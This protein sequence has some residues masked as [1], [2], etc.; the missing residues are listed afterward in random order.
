MTFFWRATTVAL[1]SYVVIHSEDVASCKWCNTL[2]GLEGKKQ[3]KTALFAFEATLCKV[4]HAS[5]H[6]LSPLPPAGGAYPSCRA[7]A[8]W[9][10]IQP[11]TLTHTHLRAIWSFSIV[12]TCMFLDYARNM[13]SPHRKVRGPGIEPATYSLTTTPPFAPK[14]CV[15]LRDVKEKK[16]NNIKWLNFRLRRLLLSLPILSLPVNYGGLCIQIWTPPSLVYLN[17][18]AVTTRPNGGAMLMAGLLLTSLQTIY[19]K[20]VYQL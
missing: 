2:F 20:S 13:Q 15:I 18:R 12:L 5:L 11:L 10:D 9:K 16:N 19:N 6:C 1:L 7:R 14:Q 8:T 4:F 17:M 3:K